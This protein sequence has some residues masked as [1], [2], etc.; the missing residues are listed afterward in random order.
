M[1]SFKITSLLVI[2]AFSLFIGLLA[3]HNFSKENT[4]LKIVSPSQD[5][6]GEKAEN[7]RERELWRLKR[8]G[9][10]LDPTI[11]QKSKETTRKLYQSSKSETRDGGLSGWT[12][13][14]PFGVGGRIRSIAINP[15]NANDIF[16]G[17]IGGGIWRTLDGGISW[18]QI[19]D[20]MQSLSITQILY[21]PFDSDI[22]YASTGEGYQILGTG[23][24]VGQQG[25]GGALSGVGIFKSTDG[26]SNWTLL[27]T[28]PGENFFWV[29]DIA[30]DPNN[31]DWI[32]AVTT[33]A[34]LTNSPST[35]NNGGEIFK[36]IDGGNSWNLI[37][38]ML[39]AGLDIKIDPNSSANIHVGCGANLYRS[40]NATNAIANINFTE[41]TG[42]PNQIPSGSRIEICY[43]PTIPNRLFASADINSGQLW[44]SDNNGLNWT[45]VNSNN[46]YITAG[47][48]ANTIWVD[49]TDA[50]RI[51]W[52]S[53]D[54]YRS[55]NN[56]VDFIKVSDWTDDIGGSQPADQDSDGINNSA[57]ADHHVIIEHPNYN[58][59][60]NRQIYNGNDG[61]IYHWNDIVTG[62]ENSGWTSLV[63]D[64]AI[65]QYYGGSISADG[66]VI[67]G[68][69]QDN[70]YSF[71]TD[72]GVTWTQST[73]G[74]GAYAAVD[75]TNSNNIYANLNN[76]SILQSTDQGA[77]WNTRAR[78]RWSCQTCNVCCSGAQCNIPPA[79][80]GCINGATFY[81]DDGALLISLFVMDP[82][83]PSTLVVGAERLWRNTLN[84]NQNFWLPIKPLLNANANP[85]NI[86]A[87]EI[88]VGFSPRIWVGYTDGTLERTTDTGA[89]WTGDIRPNN[90]PA[91]PF[92]TDI[93]VN[94]NNSNEVIVSYGGYNT[95]NIFYTE[96]GNAANPTWV[97]INL[98][99]S[100]QVNTVEWHPTNEDWVYVG[101]DYGVFA[102]ED[103]GQSWSVYPLFSV[104]EGP[105]YTEVSELF[106][107]PNSTQLCAATHGRGI[108]KS[109]IIIDKL[110]VDQ[111]TND[112]IA[113][114]DGSLNNPF[115]SLAQAIAAAANGCEIIYLSSGNHEIVGANSLLINEKHLTVTAQ[116]GSVIIR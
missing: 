107:Q 47:W 5:L 25:T 91:N 69:A 2:A 35:S 8:K 50:S 20:F 16:V 4:E 3:L 98:G 80:P 33:D 112:P 74:D 48:F 51:I 7:P 41:I 103:K 75:Y 114:Q 24:N 78:F 22:L 40:T 63:G 6:E 96:N 72:G 67:I 109:N 15:N 90:L 101:T 89:N 29:N 84:A 30:L 53:V 56:G 31:Q 55:T 39:S 42:G 32:Y 10:K 97:N 28:P 45:A 26:G 106:W 66:N 88:D 54:L 19:G 59:T 1:K 23:G 37:G 83:T 49:P 52:G 61:G 85:P 12:E 73:T 68:G 86:C 43:A 87:I 27:P 71:S 21:D 95:N 13:L 82:N 111:T 108:W 46:N 102:S 38:T 92:V 115:E 64:L 76:N 94:P 104:S 113:Q 36:S 60:T 116:N 44:R 11:I 57:H 9:G 93:C 65:T 79:A 99:L 58:G 105:V 62:T 70:S 81:V 34:T 110:Y 18:S 17:S 100:M 14:G 77:T